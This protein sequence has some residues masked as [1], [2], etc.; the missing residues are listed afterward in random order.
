MKRLPSFP[1]LLAIA[2]AAIFTSAAQAQRRPYIG[3]AYPAGAQIGT[4]V[5]VRLGGQ[6]ME[7]ATAVM[8]SGTGVTARVIDYRRRLNNQEIQ[9][10]NEQLRELKKAPAPVA[11]QMAPQTADQAASMAT[12]AVLAAPSLST[13]PG[14]ANPLQ[15]RIERRVREWV[16]T[17]AC[18]S[19][20]SLVIVAVT[21]APEAEIGTREL[22]LV[23]ARGVSNPLVFQV[24][25]LAEYSRKPMN[26]AP[27]QILG[28]EAAALRKRPPAEGEV[29]ISLPCTVNGQIA[30]G[31]VN[32]YRFTASKGQKLVIS[33]QGRQ[34]I[35]YIADAVPGWFQPVLALY[36]AKG[37]EL[38]FADDY[39]FKPDPVIL[40]QVPADGDYVFAIYDSIYR[41][42]E[43]FIY[44][45]TVGELPFATSVFPLGGQI[46]AALPP[47]L[48]GWNLRPED[49]ATRLTGA[50]PGVQTLA[51]SRMGYDSNRLPF[52]WDTL[53]DAFDREPNNSVA[54]AQVVTLPV[55]IN[56]RIQ[57]T[58]DW[59]VYS[60][61]GKAN[62][63]LVAEV[64]ARRLDSPLDSVIKLTDA[65]GKVIAFNDDREDLTAGVN[66]HPADSS[67][68][69]KLPADGTYFVHLGE[70]ARKGGDEYGYRLRLSAPRPD[71]ELRL[72][73]SSVSLPINS[74]ASVSV[75]VVRKEGFAG[76]I[77]LTLAQSIA[78]FTA[79]PVTI[80]ANQ[81][82]ARLTLKSSATPTAKPV[83]L[84]VVG[85]AKINDRDVV[86][87]AVATE[88][89]MQAFLWRHLVP[90]NDLQVVSYDTRVK[91]EPKR[92]A[93][94]VP[95]LP[96]VAPV[97][98]AAP[99]APAKPKFTKQQIVGRLR[100]LKL[101]YEE[102][103]LTDRFYVEKVAECETPS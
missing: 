79:V 15:D 97:A 61:V 18:A 38:A 2:L 24:G 56:G 47:D 63:T 93:P 55:V 12:M 39:R 50:K 74:T 88:D 68:T 103:L 36:D 45:I 78:G 90:A 96:A 7:D 89:R 37:K 75:H 77:K 31:E 3:Y 10:L 100:Q 62:Q 86:R 30:S 22:R 76:P 49:L 25:Q 14:S 51:A 35:P 82:T 23:T 8:V 65:A 41:G 34:L 81:T 5:E 32:R 99:A 95:A 70:T 4:T 72:S 29:G 9:L 64:Q 73:P 13:G 67:F 58:D 80:P 46:D 11:A 53:P 85:T 57:Q 52:A 60:F 54:A 27:I 59:D 42:R 16:Q 92:I 26:T 94:T 66:T 102:G 87:E 17:P 28:K 19:I 101:L 48:N 71:F 91:P 6:E 1:L 43:D 83:V 98:T 33:T 21:I 69:A 40:F 20:S 84:P 44:R